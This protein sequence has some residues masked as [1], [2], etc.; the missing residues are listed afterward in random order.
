MDKLTNEQ[1]ET[2]DDKLNAELRATRLGTPEREAHVARRAPWEAA[3]AL[4]Q[5]T[6]QNRKDRLAAIAAAAVKLGLL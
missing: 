5:I 1:F 6:W 3:N 2:C 4:P